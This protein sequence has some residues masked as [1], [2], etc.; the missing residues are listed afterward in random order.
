MLFIF[1]CHFFERVRNIV[2]NLLGYETL[3][4]Y[5]NNSAIFHILTMIKT[6]ILLLHKQYFRKLIFVNNLKKLYLQ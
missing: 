6:E 3:L 5:E 4:E 2:E 1:K